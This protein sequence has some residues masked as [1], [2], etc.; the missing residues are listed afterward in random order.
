MEGPR[1]VAA[2]APWSQGHS[3]LGAQTQGGIMLCLQATLRRPSRQETRAMWG[4]RKL[5]LLWCLV[6]AAGGTEHIYRPG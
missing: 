4:P 6:L 3:L 1:R 5:L 2:W